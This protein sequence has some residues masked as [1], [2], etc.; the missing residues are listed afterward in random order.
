MSRNP[1]DVT[2]ALFV[3][4]THKGSWMCL[5]HRTQSFSTV[6]MRFIAMLALAFPV[7][8]YAAGFDCAKAVSDVEKAI[9]GDTALSQLDGDLAA[10][11]QQSVAGSGNADA[12]KAAQRR[13]LKQ[14]DACGGDT[15][16]LAG[17]Y[18]AKTGRARKQCA[19]RD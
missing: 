4:E 12:L 8:S 3:D 15:V 11:W 10:A 13:W 19:R 9:C 14:R 18:R 5:R 2:L 1:T 16:C 6:K 17:R 7:A